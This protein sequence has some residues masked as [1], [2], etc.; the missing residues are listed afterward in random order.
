VRH[1]QKVGCTFLLDWISLGN[2]REEEEKMA[3]KKKFE[4]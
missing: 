3:Q 1:H 2:P 4:K